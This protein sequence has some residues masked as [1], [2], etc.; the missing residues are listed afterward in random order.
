MTPITGAVLGG[1]VGATNIK[2]GDL[3][4]SQ[5]VAVLALAGAVLASLHKEMYKDPLK[6]PVSSIEAYKYRDE[7]RA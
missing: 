5:K 7:R 4:K 2:V 6:E 1:L 3:S